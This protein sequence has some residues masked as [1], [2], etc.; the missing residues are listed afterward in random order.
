MNMQKLEYPDNH[1]YAK[2][3]IY[4]N[5]GFTDMYDTMYG[6]TSTYCGLQLHIG[7]HLYR[8]RGGSQNA[9]MPD[10]VDYRYESLAKSLGVDVAV[11]KMVGAFIGNF[12][13]R[14][15]DNVIRFRVSEEG[16]SDVVY[17]WRYEE[18]LFHEVLNLNPSAITTTKFYDWFQAVFSLDRENVVGPSSEFYDDYYDI[19]PDSVDCYGDHWS[20]DISIGK[21]VRLRL[22]LCGFSF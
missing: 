2:R 4:D 10:R 14:T 19:S 22:E 17:I 18:N 6:H 9:F 16:P 7:D 13:G 12:C 1:H 5:N 8:K 21:I 3:G 15:E 11:D 20:D